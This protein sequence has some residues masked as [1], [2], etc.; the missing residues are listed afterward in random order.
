[1][2]ATEENKEVAEPQITVPVEEEK[3]AQP[4]KEEVVFFT[5]SQIP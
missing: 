2:S 5:T 1:M 4:E 3:A